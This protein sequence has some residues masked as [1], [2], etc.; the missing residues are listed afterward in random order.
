MQLIF[1]T[2][3]CNII[4]AQSLHLSVQG[5][6]EKE[7]QIIDSIGY[8]KINSNYSELETEL[9]SLQQKINKLGYLESNLEDLT[10]ESD[11][12]Y[13]AHLHLNNHYKTIL[14][15]IKELDPKYLKALDLKTLDGY[16][17]ISIAELEDT[18]ESLNTEITN[19]GDP[20]SSLELTDLKKI[21]DYTLSAKLKI[22]SNKIRTIDGIV[23]KGYEKFPRSYVK[24]FLKIKTSQTFNLSKIKEQTN[25][26]NDLQFANQIKDPEVLFTKD[27]TTL[28]LYI[29]KTKANSF[30]GFLGFG[31]NTE[32]QNLECDGYLN[33]ALINN[34][35]YG[36][37]LNLL[38]KSDENDQRT[39]N[40]DVS[41]PY[42]FKTP[43]GID[44]NLNIFRRDSSF[45]NITQSANLF[46]Q[47]NSRNKLSVGIH[48]INSNNLLD[49]STSTITDYKSTF[50]KINYSFIKPQ[51]YD[52]LF[53][54]NFLFD[55]STGFG[56]RSSE[57]KTERQTQ[58][59][60][61]SYKIFNLNDRNSLFTRLNGAYLNSDQYLENEL[62]RFGGINSI[63]GFEENSI[64]ANLY[65]VLNTE[66]RYRL[67]N[68][69]YVHS[70]L[71]ASY[72]ENQLNNTKEKLFG[73]G[74]G[75]GLLTNTGLFKLNYSNGKT[76][77]QSFKFSDSKIHISISSTF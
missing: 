12:S 6:N 15:Y 54:T 28:Y 77:N 73:I 46:Y 61:N 65:A 37:S 53:P 10:K 45:V 68:N 27:S 11:S 64:L 7:T 63:R 23:I 55:F 14:I 70:V 4:H 2:L 33:L 48:G 75:F 59:Q 69:L 25:L 32:T 51:Y 24:H 74:F 52:N 42:L 39:F 35:N 66:Y 5:K 21:N 76:E 58:F 16:S 8:K 18:L 47:L 50:Y 44:A 3:L 71:D 41:L 62:Y 34:L 56:K 22:T 31:T 40:L 57:F 36:E 38:Y 67:S 1:W 60:V 17:L 13:V 9:F 43:I 30:D 20:F 19:T 72:F 29:E 26:L 49:N